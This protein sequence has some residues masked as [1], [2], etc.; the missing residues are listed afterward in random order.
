MASLHI[1]NARPSSIQLF[2]GVP[3]TRQDPFAETQPALRDS[4][5]LGA[6]SKE[7]WWTQQQ[8]LAAARHGQTRS[9]GDKD[10]T[11]GQARSGNWVQRQLTAAGETLGWAAEGAI[12]G[13]GSVAGA[14]AAGATRVPGLLVEAGSSVAS[15]SHVLPGVNREDANRW[16]ENLSDTGD[17]IDAA[18]TPVGDRVAAVYRDFTSGLGE[19]VGGMVEGP[20]QMAAHPVETVEGVVEMAD[21]FRQDPRGFVENAIQNVESEIAQDYDEGGIAKVMGTASGIAG[22]LIF[23]GKGI[24]GLTG[25]LRPGNNSPRPP[26]HHPPA[27]LESR[28]GTSA[29]DGPGATPVIQET[30]S[31]NRPRVQYQPSTENYGYKHPRDFQAERSA[32]D[33]AKLAESIRAQVAAR[34]KEGFSGGSLSSM[35]FVEESR[36]IRSQAEDILRAAVQDGRITPHAAQFAQGAVQEMIVKDLR[37]GGVRLH[38]D[39]VQHM[40]KGRYQVSRETSDSIE[41][42]TLEPRDYSFQIATARRAMQPKPDR[43]TAGGKEV[44]VYN[45]DPNNGTL[46]AAH[47]ALGDMARHAPMLVSHL[48]EIHFVDNLRMETSRV[49]LS[50]GRARTDQAGVYGNITDPRI[51]EQFGADRAGSTIHVNA[52]SGLELDAPRDTV[53]KYIER[54]QA[55]KGTIYHEAAHLL[56]AEMDGTGRGFWSESSPDSPFHTVAEAPVEDFVSEYARVSP[57]EDFAGT[58]RVVMELAVGRSTENLPAHFR[59]GRLSES[60]REKLLVTAQRIGADPAILQVIPNWHT[61]P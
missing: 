53:G 26:G 30:Q 55:R 42:R 25:R 4:V 24:G 51:A 54:T 48:Q 5:D 44:A 45:A 19:Q 57:K 11:G 40:M 10:S 8:A 13:A 56:D 28:T 58:A 14:V 12:E 60:L 20:F 52:S 18:L 6:S 47:I 9:A 46:G 2:S 31:S 32:Y 49:S 1:S 29:S 36:A 50:N 3:V 17:Q 22:E 37:R 7:S 34:E 21:A 23:G 61:E 27:D 43:V 39:I 33:P 38:P 59:E 35:S 41:S 15:V 16:S